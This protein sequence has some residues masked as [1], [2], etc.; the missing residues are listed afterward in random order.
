MRKMSDAMLAITT[1][2]DNL[3][4][5]DE[6]TLFFNFKLINHFLNNTL[7]FYFQAASFFLQTYDFGSTDIRL[8]VLETGLNNY[9]WVMDREQDFETYFFE[10]F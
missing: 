5:L 2:F 10:L 4:L 9:L 1:S 3:L 7:F 8:R 6:V